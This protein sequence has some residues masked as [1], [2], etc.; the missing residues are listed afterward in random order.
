MGVS[1]D[2]ERGSR[3]SRDKLKMEISGPDKQP[4]T[5]VDL[6]GL[7]STDSRQGADVA[8]VKEIVSEY[9]SNPRSIILAILS[10]N[11]DAE[12]QSIIARAK[13]VDPDGRRTFGIV[14]KPD[15]PAQ[16]SDLRKSWVDIA[17]NRREYKFQKGWHVLL[18]RDFLQVREGTSTV[19]RDQNERRFFNDATNEWNAISEDSWGIDA[20]RER[21]RL[22]LYDLTR[23][24]LPRVQG[25]IVT[26][27]G[28]IEDRL[29]RL[30]AGL[31]SQEEMWKLYRKICDQMGDRVMIG[32]SGKLNDHFFNTSNLDDKRYLRSTIEK[33]NDKLS[34]DLILKGHGIRIPTGHHGAAIDDEA[35]VNK[36]WKILDRTGGEELKGHTDP[37]RLDLLFW[38]HSEPWKGIALEHIKQCFLHCRSFIEYIVTS[39]LSQEL[40]RVPTYLWR[41]IIHKALKE[42]KDK[43]EKELK[44]IDEDRT[45]STKTRNK[46]FLEKSQEAR[47]QKTY[48]LVMRA[49]KAETAV[50]PDLELGMTPKLIAEELELD[51]HEKVRRAKA[52]EMLID[53]LIY[54]N[55]SNHC[56]WI[57]ASYLLECHR[58]L[59][60]SSSITFLSRWSRDTS[61]QTSMRCSEMVWI[62][63]EISSTKSGRTTT[64]ISGRQKG[65]RFNSRGI[66]Y[67]NV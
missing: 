2:P 29:D 37:Q 46:T 27:L 17:S 63:L 66:S 3:F 18:N 8:T 49:L 36:V 62:C 16:G 64:T 42:R 4:L 13:R 51:T 33:Q 55:V 43:A 57:K 52:E 59:E 31:K 15:L 54:Y 22:L 34:E 10:A 20:L 50:T 28:K 53:M 32:V 9:I 44:N 40:P 23:E 35:W 11:T 14:T 60:T 48:N 25:D 56:Y 38:E 1:R 67:G 58:L 21:L 47:N 61:L 26:K 30:G 5:L 65:N 19:S 7:I 12:N 45:R 39:H 41:E 24:T 6:P